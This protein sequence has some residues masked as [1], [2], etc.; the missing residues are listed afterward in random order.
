MRPTKN[1][2]KTATTSSEM[3]SLRKVLIFKR[4]KHDNLIK[5]LRLYRA[6][7][8]IKT[9]NKVH[10]QALP[11]PQRASWWDTWRHGDDESMIALT[12][13]DRKSFMDLLCEFSKNYI[14]H[15]RGRSQKLIW[16]HQVLALL[17]VL[18]YGEHR[19]QKFVSDIWTS[20]LNV[21][22]HSR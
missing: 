10:A 14:R 16:N 8:S 3:K 2:P 12:S 20:S 18:L 5:A 7:M 17:L 22:A 9:R 1:G 15:R 11:T 4:L 19:R 6:R 21:R 13:L